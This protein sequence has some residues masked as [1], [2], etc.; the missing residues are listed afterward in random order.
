MKSLKKVASGRVAGGKGGSV[1]S[2]L[3]LNSQRSTLSSDR[4][5]GAAIIVVLSLLGTLAFLGLLFYT[6]AAQELANAENFATVP[7]AAPSFSGFADFGIRQVIVGTP[8]DLEDSALFGS[9]YALVPNMIGRPNLDTQ[10]SLADGAGNYA[11]VN[12]FDGLGI[13]VWGDNS[14][15]STGGFIFDYDGDGV[16]DADQDGLNALPAYLINFSPAANGGSIPAEMTAFH[17]DAGYTYPDINSLYLAFDGFI[18]DP[19]T[20]A[21][22]R[23]IIPSYHRPQYFPAG[24]GIADGTTLSPNPVGSNP[25]GFDAIYTAAGTANQVLRPHQ[26]HVNAGNTG[27]ARFLSATTT[28][29]SGDTT[30]SIDPFPVQVDINSNSYYNQ[31]GIWSVPQP[32]AETP[33]YFDPT[34][35]SQTIYEYDVDCDGDGFRDAIWMDLDYP[36]VTLSDGRQFVPL[37]AFKIVDL[38]A[39]LNVNAHG[40]MNGVLARDANGDPAITGDLLLD[41]ASSSNEG[42][43]RSEVNLGLGLSADPVAGELDQHEANFGYQPSNRLE[44]S[45]QELLMLLN[46]RESYVENPPTVFTRDSQIEGR[47]AE[48]DLIDD[49]YDYINGAPWQAAPSPGGYLA[50]DDADSNN[51]ADDEMNAP[52][53]HPLGGAA[54]QDPNLYNAWVPPF[55][56]PLDSGGTGASSIFPN[57]GV[58]DRLVMP[59]ATVLGVPENPAI[60]LDYIQSPWQYTQSS[61]G[62]LAATGVS[63]YWEA[64]SA[65]LHEN[66]PLND[67]L[68]DEGNEVI[69]NRSFRNPDYDSIFPASELDGLALSDTDFASLGISNRL[70][71]LLIINLDKGDAD[72]VSRIRQRLTTDSWDRYDF[73]HGHTLSGTE[74]RSWEFNIWGDGMTVA[75]DEPA[76]S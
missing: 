68:L 54:Y 38:D 39:L 2:Q 44:L 25:T 18:R 71:D 35:P 17:P 74:D 22:Y 15:L 53:M 36:I 41:Y 66:E 34:D 60:W 75:E 23:V 55:V 33:L 61:A 65:G 4:R 12:P 19:N 7:T 59:A 51:A 29:A 31:A 50:D 14:N 58:Y 27:V 24:R 64:L 3:A 1:R 9:N 37:Y 28:A 73:G 63:S 48:G 32:D 57:G 69:L 30:R 5:G 43:A 72:Q 42:L 40:N 52:V 56:Q 45:N 62:A 70:R 11:D 26:S 20:G 6:F 49:F 76:D 21:E 46:G 47:W 8:S 16:A 10:V 67:F 13:G